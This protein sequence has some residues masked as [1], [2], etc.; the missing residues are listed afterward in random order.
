MLKLPSVK[1]LD[2]Q[3][4]KVLLRLDLDVKEIDENDLRIK[5]ASETLDFLKDKASEVIII[6][7]RGRPDGKVDELLSLKPFQSYFDRWGAKVE[8]NLRF[9]KGEEENDSEYAKRLSQLADVYVNDAFASSHREHASIVGLPKLRPSA[10]G[11]HFI[12]EVENLNKIFEPERPLVILISGVKEDKL[13]MIEPLSTLADKVLVGGRLPDYLGDK[14]LV[15]VRLQGDDQKVI[16]GNLIMD[17]EDITLN[18]IDR[19]TKEVLKAKTILLAGV[20]GKYEDEGHSQGTEKVFKAVANCQ[21]FKI[22]GGG[23]TIN[24]IMRYNLQNKFDWIS[25][26]GGATLEFLINKTLPGIEALIH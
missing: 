13:K 15:S 8:E 18:T 20:L 6:G 23:D 5:A 22:S 16:I 9:D 11:I 12:K 26:G 7:H 19:F 10:F 24:A 1:D 21:A 25:V 14:G 17:K 4:K 2:V 3:G